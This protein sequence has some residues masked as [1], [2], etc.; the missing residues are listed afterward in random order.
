LPDGTDRISLSQG[1]KWSLNS[2]L[3]PWKLFRRNG[4]KQARLFSMESVGITWLGR[5]QKYL[6]ATEKRLV[7][8]A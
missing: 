5:N 3:S 7:E 6:Q 2:G 1:R 4:N 8:L